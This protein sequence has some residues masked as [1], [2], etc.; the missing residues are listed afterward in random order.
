VERSATS[1]SVV[2]CGS[3]A[4]SAEP[5][6]NNRQSTTAVTQVE[7]IS[8]RRDGALDIFRGIAITEVLIHHV[9]AFAMRQ[10]AAGTWS[11]DLFAYLNR[12]LHFAVP[13]F[14]FI[15]A[16]LLT[17]TMVGKARSWREFYERRARQ[18]LAPYLIW[19]VFYVCFRVLV[20]PQDPPAVLL[21]MDRWRVWLLWGKAWYHL[22][23]MVLALQLYLAFPI[24]LTALRRTRVGL[25]ALLLLGLAAQVAVHW[26]HARWIRSPF[27][28]SLLFWYVMPVLSGVWVGIHLEQWPE[29]WRRL[30]PVA[31]PLML[32]GWAIY[33]PQG[34]R[35]IH[36][37][38][39]QSQLYHFSYWAYTTGVAFCLLALC[40]RLDRRGGRLARSLRT[41]GTYSMPIYLVH[42]MLLHLWSM[43]PLSGSTL[44]FHGTIAVVGLSVFG[45]SLLVAW[46]AAGTVGGRILFG[47]GDARASA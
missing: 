7:G 23:F 26:A 17:R 14:L 47:R 42:P 33:L 8:R 15:M 13:A 11:H 46:L 29:V 4:V 39:V 24:L 25:G 38:P 9:S 12:T 30:R 16:V 22:Y 35:Q 27:P 36:G 21:D 37:L 6:T 2:G 32:L 45:I 41:L 3:L 20:V 1:K 40:R 28:A 5:V 43:V 19:S 18:T 34:Y 31:L 10:T 44:R